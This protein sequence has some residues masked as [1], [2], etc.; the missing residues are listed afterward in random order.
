VSDYFGERNI[1]LEGALRM[2]AGMRQVDPDSRALM[3]AF[4]GVFVL[5]SPQNRLCEQE[6]LGA[7]AMDGSYIVLNGAWLPD[8]LSLYIVG[9][10]ERAHIYHRAYSA[11]DPESER[12][13]QA[14][15]IQVLAE[16]L[17]RKTA[18]ELYEAV[19]QRRLAAWPGLDSALLRLMAATDQGLKEAAAFCYLARHKPEARAPKHEAVRAPAA[20]SLHIRE[21]NCGRV[22]RQLVEVYRPVQP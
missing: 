16:S 10:H 19:L 14:H 17:D 21:S 6:R 9:L 4:Q 2:P 20:R 1:W 8:R 18:A 15:V 11:D 7:A 3:P 13:C 12:I 5:E 22:V